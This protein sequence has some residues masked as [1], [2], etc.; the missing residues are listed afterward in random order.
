MIKYILVQRLNN[1]IKDFQDIKEK[2]IVAVKYYSNNMV[3]KIAR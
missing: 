1:Y 2:K 3:L